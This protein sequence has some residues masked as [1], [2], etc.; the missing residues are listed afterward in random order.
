MSEFKK[1]IEE[2]FNEIESLAK[3]TFKNQKD[4]AFKDGKAFL[5]KIENDLERLSKLVIKGELT[6]EEFKWLVRGKKDLAEM[7]MLKQ[8]GLAMVKIDQF[9]NS[10]L[11]LVIGHLLKRIGL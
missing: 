8:A 5:D 11:D 7:V 6:A 2:I 10:L 4:E 1:I 3:E 9:K